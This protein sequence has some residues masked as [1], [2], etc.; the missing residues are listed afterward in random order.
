VLEARIVG[1]PDPI[2]GE[3]VCAFVIPRRDRTAPDVASLASF[4]LERG[5]AKFK[6][7]ERVESIDEFPMTGVGK[8]DRQALRRR[9]SERLDA[10][11]GDEAGR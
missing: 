10:E 1:I 9:V 6:L 3:R 2:V 7:P 4:L 8:L 11:N 5:L